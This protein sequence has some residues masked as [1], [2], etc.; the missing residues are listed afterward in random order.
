[1]TDTTILELKRSEIDNLIESLERFERTKDILLVIGYLS[2]ASLHLEK[3]IKN[4]KNNSCTDFEYVMSLIKKDN[5][6]DVFKDCKEAKWDKTLA[7]FQKVFAKNPIFRN[8]KIDIHIQG[9]GWYYLDINSSNFNIMIHNQ[10]E[11]YFYCKVT[12]REFDLKINQRNIEMVKEH[13]MKWVE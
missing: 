3:E 2:N 10:K 5:M 11:F 9:E 13:I 6:Y 4:K 1:M 8:P 12:Q 7:L